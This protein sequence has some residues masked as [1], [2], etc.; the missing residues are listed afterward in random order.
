MTTDDRARLAM[1]ALW[2]CLT[3]DHPTW[4]DERFFQ[5]VL[6][7]A[8]QHESGLGPALFGVG[9]EVR[10]CNAKQRWADLLGYDRVI[11]KRE[12]NVTH[13]VEIKMY[14][15]RIGAVASGSQLDRYFDE[16]PDAEA[17]LLAPLVWLRRNGLTPDADAA[18]KVALR[19]RVKSADRWTL[20]SFEAIRAEVEQ[21]L[22]AEAR[23]HDDFTALVVGY[24][25]AEWV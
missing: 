22:P 25:R 13:I 21:R 9:P 5:Q 18:A 10:W 24:A 4:V 6:L 17:I 12:V 19:E 8:L 16:S 2:A 15:G 14:R 20:V 3:C 23:V 7:Q 1:R 11:A